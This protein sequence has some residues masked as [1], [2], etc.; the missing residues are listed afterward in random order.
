MSKLD[1]VNNIISEIEE[2]LSET[3]RVDNMSGMDETDVLEFFASIISHLD[4]DIAIEVMEHFPKGKDIAQMMKDRV[5][6]LN[7]NKDE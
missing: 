6:L 5:V 7:Q 1:K 2:F 3:V 4:T